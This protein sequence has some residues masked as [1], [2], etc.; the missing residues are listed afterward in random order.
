M[1]KPLE[2]DGEKLRIKKQQNLEGK[3]GLQRGVVTV[4]VWV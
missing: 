2:R 4:W 3:I 1:F